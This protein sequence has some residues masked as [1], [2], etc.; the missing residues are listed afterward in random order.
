[1]LRRLRRSNL[2]SFFQLGSALTP[3]CVAGLAAVEGCGRRDRPPQPAQVQQLEPERGRLSKISEGPNSVRLDGLEPIRGFAAGRDCT[4]M[5]CL[6]LVLKGLG[7]P[8][9]YEELMG[10]SGMAFRTQVRID[11]WDVGNPDPLVGESCVEPLFA[12][13]GWQYDVQV[14]R[15]DQMSQAA[16][17]RGEIVKSLDKGTPVLAANI[18]RPEDWGIIVGY[19]ADQQWLCRSYNG[20]A[21]ERDRLANGWPTAV[22]LLGNR[23]A[24][25]ARQETIAAAIRRAIDLFNRRQVGKHALGARAFEI[26]SQN[27]RSAGDRSYIHPNAWTYVCLI[28]ARQAAARYLRDAAEEFGAKG[29]HLSKAAAHY[30]REVEALQKGY[31][32]VPSERDYPDSMPPPEMRDRQIDVILQA[33]GYEELA[34]GELEKAL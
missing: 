16:A 11:R 15:R 10:V 2:F 6:E 17:L 3:L 26:W 24:P 34:I 9:E 21:Q 29:E 25:R 14:V 18:I 12:A 31:R 28:D 1:M 22:V 30:E 23:Q 7:R 27:L 4:F 19:R 33:L 5:H 8:V 32:Y 13:I 20:G